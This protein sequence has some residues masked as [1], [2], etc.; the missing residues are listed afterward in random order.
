MSDNLQTLR[1]SCEHLLNVA[2]TRL[3]PDLK[4]AMGPSTEDG[5]Y[6]DFDF[7]PSASSGQAKISEEDFPKI[8]KE[9]EKIVK[10]DLP[11]VRKEL[12]VEE[13]RPLF[14][15]NPYKQEWL[16]EIEERGE[17]A[18]VYWTGE[19]FVDLCSGPHVES[20]DRVG[21]FKLLSIAGAYWR[22]SEKNKMLTRIYGTCFET[23]EELEEY[24]KGLEE[25]KAHDHRVIGKNLNLFVFSE[26]VGK[27][28]PLFT[29]KGATIRRELERF[30]VDEEIKRGY[31]HVCTP[32]LAKV[33]LYKT[34]GHY[35]Y[36]R[37]SMYPVMKID[38]EELILRP[39]TCPH[40]FQLYLSKQ[41]SYRDLPIRYAELAK[42]FRYEKSGE[43]SGLLRVRTFC[44]ADG[45]IICRKDQAVEEIN[46][47]LGLIEYVTGIFGLEK[48]TDF[49]YR[50][51]LGDRKDDKKYYKDNTA[52]DF[53]EKVLRDVLSSRKSPFFEGEGEAAFY[54]PKIDIQMKNVSGKEET[55][56]TVQ[57]DFVMP[58]RFKM[59]YVGSDGKKEE[60][61][62]IHRS[63]IGCI[64]RVMAF[65]IE[66][67]AGALPV[68]L[69]PTQAIVIPITDLQN[70]YGKDIL[71]ALEKEGIRAEMDERNDTISSKIRDAEMQKIP[72][73]IIVGAKEVEAKNISLRAKGETC[74]PAGRKNMGQMKLD[75]FTGK[76][77]SEIE[78]KS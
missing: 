12:T 34:S 20:T 67:Y 32:D 49:R 72:Y 75:E 37:D 39:M 8:E 3:Y 46:Q 45:H 31:R 14:K 55:A 42:Q 24:L 5:F 73:M 17:K 52:W 25:V 50:L 57:Y 40:H 21:P 77:K 47:A 16:D 48:G 59:E 53:A 9:M 30:V 54:G 65:L 70:D 56:F 7:D 58:K 11:F 71:S 1:H 78:K 66:K 28:L 69:S 41:R 35:P 26:L 23:K 4:M 62:V 43:L 44:L 6:F 68:W 63:S 13:A 10:E 38:E 74:L 76:I 22:G 27:G 60:P 36:Y 18:V 19:D 2:M 51:S 61:I 64:E 33:D 29:E 15:G